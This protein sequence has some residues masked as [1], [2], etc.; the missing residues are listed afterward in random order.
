M[1]GLHRYRVRATHHEYDCLGKLEQVE[2][3][4]VLRLRVTTDQA[5]AVEFDIKQNKAVEVFAI[6]GDDLVLP[7]LIRRV[8]ARPN[9]SAVDLACLLRE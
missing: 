6:A 3:T 7:A 5:F 9:G 4:F 2:G 8:N 1:I